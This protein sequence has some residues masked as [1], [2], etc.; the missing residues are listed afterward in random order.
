MIMRAEITSVILF[1]NK[2]TL[3]KGC[4][5]SFQKAM[6]AQTNRKKTSSLSYFFEQNFLVDNG[7]SLINYDTIRNAST[8]FKVHRIENNSG[9]SKG[10]NVGLKASFDQPNIQWAI[11]SS[12][13]VCLPADFYINLVELLESDRN[14]SKLPTILCPRVYFQMDKTKLS[15]TC[16]LFSQNS[17]EL[18]HLKIDCSQIE[19][20]YYYPAALTIWNKKAYEILGGFSENYFCYWEDVDLSL[21]A[22]QK[23]VALTSAPTLHIYHLGRG[24][25]AGKNAYYGH[26]MKGKQT[27]L[28]TLLFPGRI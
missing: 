8:C 12:N 2:P 1:F 4:I 3:T 5:D 22:S 21:R 23:N 20:P 9:F 14:L 17:N 10:M 28:E 13:D 25:T 15:Y 6:V 27:F 11:L 26:F 18:S 16:G 24:T 7:S 19:F